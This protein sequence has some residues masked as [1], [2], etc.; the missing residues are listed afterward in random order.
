MKNEISLF[1]LF[2]SG[3]RKIYE[4]MRDRTREFLHDFQQQ[5]TRKNLKASWTDGTELK[6]SL[7][8]DAATRDNE[9]WIPKRI[10]KP[11]DLCLLEKSLLQISTVCSVPQTCIEKRLKNTDT[12]AIGNDKKFPV[13]NSTRRSTAQAWSKRNIRGMRISGIARWRVYV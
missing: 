5:V 1:F 8:K 13:W 3:L 12:A 9:E 7:K 11:I 4:P 6:K 10:I 2:S